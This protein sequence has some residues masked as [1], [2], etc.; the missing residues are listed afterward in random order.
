MVPFVS[1]ARAT[2]ARFE[3]GALRQH[4]EL[5]LRNFDRACTPVLPAAGGVSD[6][7]VRRRLHEHVAR[8]AADRRAAVLAGHER[9]AARVHLADLL[10]ESVLRL[11]S[12]NQFFHVGALGGR[13]VAALGLRGVPDCL[14]L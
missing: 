6:A 3:H 11:R 12:L 10:L 5:R 13:E 4:R 9:N 2:D 1:T 7:L 14:Y 8:S